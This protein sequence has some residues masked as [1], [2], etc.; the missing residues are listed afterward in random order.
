M[1]KKA[2]NVSLIKFCF[3][4]KNENLSWTLF[5]LNEKSK[6]WKEVKKSR[7]RTKLY[8]QVPPL[9]MLFLSTNFS[10]PLQL[11]FINLTTSRENFYFNI[12]KLWTAESKNLVLYSCQEM[13]VTK[14][15]Q[16]NVNHFFLLNDKSIFGLVYV[17]TETKSIFGSVYVSTETKS[18]PERS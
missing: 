11:L 13:K 15:L 17:L 4:D 18:L 6:Y 2:P 8:Q 12:G 1:T 7:S 5:F 10:P 16:K 3:L 14:M 9:I